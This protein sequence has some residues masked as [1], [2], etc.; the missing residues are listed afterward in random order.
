[1]DSTLKNFFKYASGGIVAMLGISLYI[2]ADT[3]FISAGCGSDGLTAL[4]IALPV[5]SVV[6]GIGLMLGM[7]GATRFILLN[8]SGKKDDANSVFTAT[9]LLGG[10]FSLVFVLCGLSL[11]EEIATLIGASPEVFHMT[12]IYLRVILLF[13]PAFIMND[14]FVCFVRC[15]GAPTLAMSSTL[16]GSLFNIVFDYI[17]IFPMGLG[18][19]GA[20]LATGAAPVIG[21]IIMSLHKLK[22]KNTF[23][24]AKSL[25]SVKSTLR[26]F[27]LGLPSL[28]TELSSGV[29]ILVFN[30]IILAIEGNTGVAAYGVIANTVIVAV[31][32][33]TGLAQGVQPLFSRAHG[34][35]DEKEK[36]KLLRYSVF[37]SLAISAVIY[38]SVFLFTK[39]ITAVFNTEGNAELSRLATLGLKLYFTS[40]FFT[41]FN[42]I[43]SVFFTSVD[44][45]MPSHAISILRGLVIIVPVAFLMAYLWGIAGVWLSVAVTEMAVALVGL[46]IYAKIKGNTKES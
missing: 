32:I 19:F 41:G 26:I 15:D 6:N 22:R 34:T 24:F 33:H 9:V 5:Y 42:I 14:I 17:F 7:G 27:A 36:R 16:F 13:S 46:G 1:M 23:R 31:C 25:P 29:V 39:Q 8:S 12:E 18:I 20:V 40:V 44:R 37:L 28:I 30:L 35:G 21:L 2:L 10:L 43:L 4:N 38:V 45:P 11:S 3:F